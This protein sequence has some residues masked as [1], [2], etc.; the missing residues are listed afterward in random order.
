M[1]LNNCV[2]HGNHSHFI[3]FLFFAV[4]G[5][6][7]AAII[8]ICSLYAGIYRD[9]FVYYQQYSRA[10]VRLTTW[11]LILTV[12]NIGLSIG[13]VIAV[14]MLLFFQLKSILKNRT[15]IED[16]I[17]DKA[18]YRRKA[19]MKA[20]LEAG[21]DEY[22]VAPFV[23]PYDLGRRKNLAQVVNFSCLPIGD[24][25]SW[26]VIDG[27]DQYTLTVSFVLYEKLMS[28]NRLLSFVAR[29]TCSKEGETGKNTSLSD[30]C[31]CFREL[32]AFVVSGIQSL[33]TS[34]AHR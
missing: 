20:A 30:Y 18:I 27:A 33:H 28:T 32:D 23:Y 22:Q 10:T 8:L 12:F 1:Y 16:W 6:S 19:M 3:W 17:I 7:H 15:G 14:G 25:V 21:D 13:V 9:Y 11:S 26:P 24:G 4:V 2:G 34:T 5:C 29:T 31:H